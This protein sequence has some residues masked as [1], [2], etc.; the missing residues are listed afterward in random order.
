M[1]EMILDNRFGSWLDNLCMDVTS[2]RWAKK[3]K[4]NQLNPQAAPLGLLTGQHF[5]RPNPAHLQ[6]KILDSFLSKLKRMEAMTGLF[7][8]ETDDIIITD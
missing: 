1:L 6:K 7:L 4:K 3:E 5:A 8:T 2:G